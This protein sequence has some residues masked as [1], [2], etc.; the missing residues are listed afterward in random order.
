MF[1]SFDLSPKRI[2]KWRLTFRITVQIRNL[3]KALPDNFFT[4]VVSPPFVFVSDE[5]KGDLA[6]LID[7]VTNWIVPKLKAAYFSKPLKART[8]I[9]LLKNRE[10]YENFVRKYGPHSYSGE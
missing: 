2:E 9:W 10:S 4:I 8:V 6:V 5:E 3:K 7:R 1:V